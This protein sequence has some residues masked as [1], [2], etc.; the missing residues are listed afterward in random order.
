MGRRSL[1]ALLLGAVGP[2]FWIWTDQS[3]ALLPALG[4]SLII[5][6]LASV[7]WWWPTQ[8]S[9]LLTLLS[10]IVTIP[11]FYQAT[12]LVIQLKGLANR[13]ELLLAFDRLIFR[14]Y[15]K[16]GQISL[17][18]D[19]HPWLG[20][21]TLFGRFLTEILQL[22]YVSYYVWGYGLFFLLLIRWWQSHPSDEIKQIH[23]SN[24]NRFTISWVGAYSLN[25]FCY[26]ALPAI[27][28]QFVFAP[29]YTHRL[30]GLIGL[31][32]KFRELVSKNQAVLQ[33]CFPS[34]HTAI[35]WLVALMALR[36]APRYGRAATVAAALITA[37]TLYLRY[38]YIVDLIAAVPLLI[39]SLF[40]GKILS[41][42]S[43]K[44]LSSGQPSLI[45]QESLSR[46]R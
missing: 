13:D 18:L 7:E 2:F 27:G 41:R 6:I 8:I 25:F 16:Q 1:F 10:W 42:A 43:L 29:D 35:S 3:S 31:A 24:L 21:H 9:R 37:A 4:L 45:P 20:P 15:F 38:H 12:G 23:F 11:V 5:L 44:D 34:G 46:S 40:L 22:A 28:P 14:T 30:G 32:E 19:I 17:W 36:Y 26:I 33:D 39:A